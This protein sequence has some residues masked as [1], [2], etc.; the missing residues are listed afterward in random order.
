MQ[1]QVSQYF[2][3]CHAKNNT[4]GLT[5]NVL[6]QWGIEQEFQS[7]FPA[8]Q[9]CISAHLILMCR[10]KIHTCSQRKQEQ[11]HSPVGEPGQVTPAL[12]H[13]RRVEPAMAETGG[14]EAV[15]TCRSLLP[16]HS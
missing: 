13:Q 5:V 7:F 4:P 14:E 11:L 3:F 8:S 10:M 9:G 15:R 1:L 6:P 12:Q 2:N 16:Q